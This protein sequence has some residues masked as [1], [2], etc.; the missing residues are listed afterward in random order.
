MPRKM[1]VM[2]DQVKLKVIIDHWVLN[3]AKTK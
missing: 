3:D 1:A 2:N